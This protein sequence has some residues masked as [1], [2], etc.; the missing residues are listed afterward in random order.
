MCS[1][2][3]HLKALQL[4]FMEILTQHNKKRPDQGVN[5]LETGRRDYYCRRN[6]NLKTEK[7]HILCFI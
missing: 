3:K 1:A 2:T 4:N 6:L 7:M 5:K